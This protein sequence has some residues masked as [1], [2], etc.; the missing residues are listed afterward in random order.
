[1]S[2]G[3][4]LEESCRAYG[5]RVAM[6][7][8]GEKLTYNDLNRAVNGVSHYLKS[9]GIKKDDKI[10]LMLP[11]CPAF[12]ISYFAVQKIGAVAVTLNV[13]STAYELIHFLG[14]SESKAFITTASL[15]KRYEDIKGKVPECRHLIVTDA[16]SDGPGF[17]KA[18]KD[19]PFELELV[20]LTDDDAAVII[21]TSGL[22]SKS[23]GAVLTHGN[24][25]G[26]SE[27]L[28]VLCGTTKE[29]RGLAIIPFFHSFGAVANMLCAIRVGASMVLM[30]RFTLDGI[31]TAIDREK[32]TFIAAVPR[33]FLGML[34]FDK[35][36]SVDISSL[37]LCITGG[38]PMPPEFIP[39]FDEKFGI[40]IMEGYGL[41]E[42]SPVCSF[43]R[44]DLPRKPGSIG[45]AI[46]G[47][48]ARVLD[49]RDQELPPGEIGELVVRGYN[50]MKGYY[51]DPEATADVI[52][53][54][55][56]HTGDLAKIDQ[57]GYIFI[58]GRKKRMII[59]SGFNVYPRDVE[60]VLE[61]HPAV[62]EAKV[63]SKEDLMRGEIVKALVVAKDDVAADE[64]DIMKHCRAYLSAY[65]VPRELEIVS[66]LGETAP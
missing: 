23:L 47:V 2:L 54:G 43:S 53:S 64:K 59:T 31:M 57:Q 32:V 11:N 37:K 62:K 21:Y 52:R 17:Q 36:E 56:L 16:E 4:M 34:L 66:N 50:V 60:K 48:E 26:Q 35:L 20:E 51:G 55:W 7:H 3:K 15:A 25:M 27:L 40:N 12:I 30:E 28:K 8:E 10:G 9:L 63:I 38:A 42:A 46:P 44:L 49:D 65:K 24:L 18:V 13:M 22:T 39:Q 45:V 41:T 19:G 1:M 58:T 61:L 33:V 29:D 5:D 14:D 6:I